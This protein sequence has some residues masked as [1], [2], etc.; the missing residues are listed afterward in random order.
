MWDKWF[1]RWGIL[2]RF[3]RFQTKEGEKAQ[4]ELQTE[5]EGDEYTISIYGGD[6]EE[7]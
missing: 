1:W 5:I 7:W 6:T 2:R 4:E 3:Q